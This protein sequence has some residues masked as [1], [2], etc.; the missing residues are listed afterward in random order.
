MR[1]TAP[2]LKLHRTHAPSGGSAVNERVAVWL[3]G[4]VLAANQKNALAI[5]GIGIIDPDVLTLQAFRPNR[6]VIDDDHGAV[7]GDKCMQSSGGLRAAFRWGK[8]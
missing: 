1:S 6:D 7:A 3:Y 4:N 2:G 8:S 5:V